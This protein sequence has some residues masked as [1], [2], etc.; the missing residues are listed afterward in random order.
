MKALSSLETSGHTNPVT[1]HHIPK[2]SYHQSHLT[3]KSNCREC[4]IQLCYVSLYNMQSLHRFLQAILFNNKSLHQPATL[5][6]S[7]TCVQAFMS[8][9][10]YHQVF[11]IISGFLTHFIHFYF[12]CPFVCS[13]I[14]ISD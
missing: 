3:V 6:N 10:H 1:M 8:R 7:E 2:D 9:H 5:I 12:P 14:K 11:T 13:F 4:C